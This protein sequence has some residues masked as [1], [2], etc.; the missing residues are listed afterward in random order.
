MYN[1][2]IEKGASL[3]VYD[4]KGYSVL[5]LASEKGNLPL[6]QFLIQNGANV[7]YLCEEKSAFYLAFESNQWHVVDFLRKYEPEYQAV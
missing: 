7:H 4:P 1:K 2:L 3:E 5:Q 6:V